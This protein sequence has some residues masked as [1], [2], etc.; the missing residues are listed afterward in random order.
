MPLLRIGPLWVGPS[1]THPSIGRSFPVHELYSIE[2]MTKQKNKQMRIFKN[3][4]LGFPPPTAKKLCFTTDPTLM[5]KYFRY[6][7]SSFQVWRLCDKIIS[8]IR[9]LGMAWICFLPSTRLKEGSARA[10]LSSTTAPNNSKTKNK[11]R[12]N[13]TS[14][15]VP[16]PADTHIHH[17]FFQRSS[18]PFKVFVSVP[19]RE[20][21][22]IFSEGC[23]GWVHHS[24]RQCLLTFFQTR[25][26]LVV[27]VC[28]G[29]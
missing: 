14:F 29:V 15:P 26:A 13:N 23:S 20:I 1:V 5:P 28:E 8:L 4:S 22:R 9:I 16:P 19:G 12:S 6:K 17:Q 24:L 10:Y 21:Q 7:I 3:L 11:Q 27:S 2:P 25:S 18:K